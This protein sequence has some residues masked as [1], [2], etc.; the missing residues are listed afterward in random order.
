MR[1]RL[2]TPGPTPVPEETL[3]ELALPVFYHR[4]PEFKAIFTELTE[5][6]KYVYCT[7]NPVVTLA[8][9]GTGGMEASLVSA[10]PVGGKVICLIAGRWG[11]RWRNICKAFGFQ[12]ISVEVPYGQAVTVEQLQQA[13]TQHPDAAAVCATL[14]E[15]ATGVVGD[16]AGFGKLIAPTSALFLVDAISGL[17]AVECRTDEWNVDLCVTGSQ[18]AMMMPPG[19]AFVSVSD[20]AQKA[21]AAVT[22]PRVFYFDLKKYVAKVLEGDTPW[23]PANT[24]IKAMRHSLKRLRNEGIENVW[25]RHQ[26]LAESARAGMQAL[27]LELFASKPASALTVVH[28]PAGLD[29]SALLK[30]LEKTYGLKL[31]GGQDTLKGKIIRVSHMGY[32][33]QFD[34]LAALA[35][36]ELA[37]LEMGHKVE[38]GAAVSAAQRVWATYIEGSRKT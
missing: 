6:L 32:V 27:G 4:S 25:T 24:L 34:V 37:L 3:Q 21:M 19:L 26:R 15:T 18:K 5:D 20:K 31:A 16:I 22:N 38:P 1:F 35:G 14:C 9:S 29:A 2:L 28:V 12:A 13:L 36:L 10:V 7:K 33:D 8:A 23:T 17:G 30:K 11:E